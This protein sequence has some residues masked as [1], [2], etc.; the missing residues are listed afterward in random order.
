[1]STMG[2]DMEVA[3]ASIPGDSSRENEDWVAATATAAVV[4]DGVS[5]PPEMGSGCRHG[6]AWFSRQVGVRLLSEATASDASLAECLATAIRAVAA[7]HAGTCDL[8]HPGTPSAT[9]ILV[10]ERSSA[11]EYLVLSDSTLLLDMAA[12]LLIVRDDR[13]EQLL[14]EKVA[15]VHGHRTGS[16]HHKERLAELIEAQRKLR[17]TPGG[18]WLAASTPDAA[19]HAITGTVPLDELRRAVLLS[20]GAT[21]L[22][23]VYGRSTW[24]AVLDRLSSAGPS[25][26]L[27][28][29][30]TVEAEDPHGQR[31][32]RYKRSDDATVVLAVP[33]RNPTD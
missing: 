22:V 30:R 33:T 16:T 19:S 10:R 5:S 6:V 8:S 27:G 14:Q 1:M 31:W 26:F 3:F 18:Y 21:A 7:L 25:A 28:D 2:V 4:L 23:D 20:D 32:P 17:N 24:T 15:A 12:G 11:L 9:V 29:V 13:S